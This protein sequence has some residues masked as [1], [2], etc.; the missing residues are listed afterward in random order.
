MTHVLEYQ[1]GT[2]QE[3]ME[4]LGDL[5]VLIPTPQ[6][7]YRAGSERVTLASGK[8]RDFGWPQASWNFPML[9]LAQRDYLRSFC[10][11]TSEIVYIRTSTDGEDLEYKTFRAVMVRPD[12]E[13]IR[14]ELVFN[15]KI[16]FIY[17]IEQAEI[18]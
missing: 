10:D 3:L 17:M 2:T 16:S 8:V 14:A 12:E 11:S 9:T 4:D 6:A 7:T 18:S 13:D 15:L 5:Y 1:I